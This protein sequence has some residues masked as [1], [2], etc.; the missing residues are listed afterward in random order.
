[1]T[2]KTGF[3]NVEAFHKAF[4]HPVE[5]SPVQPNDKTIR[6]RM[7]LILE[8]FIEFVEANVDEKSAGAQ[9]LLAPLNAAFD[10]IP[11]LASEDFNVDLVEVADALTDINYVVYGAGHCYGLD[12]DATMQEVQ[13]S[14][15]SKLGADGKPIVNEHGKIMKG[16]SYFK[17]DLKKVLAEQA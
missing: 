12:L 13:R 5:T 16:P 14:N 1:M 2:N 6:L 3:K 10:K 15:M 17:P 11:S 9:E 7:S 4:S 8:E